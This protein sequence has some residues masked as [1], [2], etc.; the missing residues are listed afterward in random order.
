MSRHRVLN[1]L[2]IL[3]AV[4]VVAAVAVAVARNWDAVSADLRRVDALSLGGAFLLA[5]LPPILT[6]LG[7]R[8]ILG[9]LGSRL[10]IA[11]AGGIFLVGQLGK[12]VP[13]SVWSVLAQA[14]MAARL[15]VPRK[16]TAVVGLVGIALGAISGLGVGVPALPLLVSGGASEGGAWVVVA[17]VALLLV[18]FWP[19]LLN[20]GIALGL[21]LLRREPLE[22]NLSGRA[23]LSAGT[24]FVAAWVTSG[25]PVLLLVRAVGGDDLGLGRLVFVSICGFALASSISMFSVVLPAGVGVREGL[26]V[27]LLGPVIG[28]SAATAV[29]VLSRFISVVVDVVC[30]LLGWAYARSHHLITSREERAHDGIRLVEDEGGAG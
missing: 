10:H 18:L 27:L 26:L 4:L 23:V 21:R 3:L 24:A 2:R 29:V 17:L 25:L 11:P 1:A 14:E 28:V 7:W 8:A 5:F 15:K 6:M 22:H 13:G 12:Y 9:D 19:P 16:R 20:W 30:A